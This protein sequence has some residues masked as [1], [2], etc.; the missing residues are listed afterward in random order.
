MVMLL[1]IVCL[2][3]KQAYVSQFQPLFLVVPLGISFRFIVYRKKNGKSLLFAKFLMLFTKF[4]ILLSKTETEI[5][6]TT[7]IRI[8]SLHVIEVMH[9]KCWHILKDTNSIPEINHKVHCDALV[10]LIPLAQLFINIIWYM[11]I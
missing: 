11:S 6:L 2:S 8:I 10:I 5:Y 7:F 4:P 1:N 9:F 3:I